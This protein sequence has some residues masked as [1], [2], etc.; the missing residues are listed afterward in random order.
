MRN[1]ETQRT[2][3]IPRWSPI[4]HTKWVALLMI[5][6]LIVS[7]ACNMH[8]TAQ[9]AHA[10]SASTLASQ[11]SW[12]NED[13]PGTNY[14]TTSTM[15]VEEATFGVDKKK[16]FIQFDLSS[17]PSGA[18]ITSATLNI[19]LESDSL[20]NVNCHV[21][22]DTW[23]E[24]GIN[25]SNAPS[26]NGSY[27]GQI[28]GQTGGEYKTLSGPAFTAIVQGWIND[29]GTNH[30]LALVG[31]AVIPL[32]TYTVTFTSRE[33]ANVPS[34]DII[35]T[36]PS[37]IGDKIWNDS[38]GDGNQDIGEVGINGI[39]VDLIQDTNG[40]GIINSGEPILDT[41]TTNG[42]GLYAFTQ[43]L[44]GD[45]IVEVTDTGNLLNEYALTGGT[46][47]RAIS[48]LASNTDYVDADFG[49][50]D[51][52]PPIIAI[53][54]LN[55]NDTTPELT[56]TVN[57][58]AAAI[59]V[60]V[61]GNGYSANNNGD[62]TWTLPDNTIAPPLSQGAYDVAASATDPTGNLGTDSTSNE[63][64]IDMTP[65]TITVDILTTN[66]TTPQLTGTVDDTAAT[67]IVAVDGDGYAA[68]NN[69]DGTWTLPDNTITPPLSQ[70]TYD[71]A[72]T[73]TDTADNTDTDSTTDELVIDTSA[74]VVTV[75]ILT[76][77]DTTPQLTG[78]VDDPTATIVVTVDGNGYTATN[79]GD[80]TWTLTDNTIAPPLSQGTYN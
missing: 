20:L 68:T 76:T 49:Y 29:P 18:I 61:D 11:D 16:A 21:V 53:D 75:D 41:Q 24:I 79:N 33:G 38:N 78:N 3:R 13:S 59:A 44:P 35:Y 50:Q 73:A 27:I 1:G 62:G 4:R 55:T 14:G 8:I 45:Y 80:G 26:Y 60:T 9:S 40:N 52:T 48:G 69:G 63:L 23:T 7:M 58:T 25:W 34:L 31:Q 56:G 36:L 6:L 65:P 30:G 67:I 74:P 77:N 51:V 22:N 70:G 42:D 54:S 15:Q 19:Y 39:T 43:L 64:V 47:P 66:D 28:D 46:N 72:V 12:I 5:M 71:V 57:D 17:I 10:D 37:S 2:I 32:G